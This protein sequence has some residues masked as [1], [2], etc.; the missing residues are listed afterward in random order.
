MAGQAQALYH[1]GSVS[2]GPS[3]GHTRNEGQGMGEGRGDRELSNNK[4]TNRHS[5][6]LA[7][8]CLSSRII[9][10]PRHY[11]YHKS[12]LYT[13]IAT[14]AA[15]G[16]VATV[17]EMWPIQTVLQPQIDAF[18]NGQCTATRAVPRH[19][20]WKEQGHEQRHESRE[21]ICRVVGGLRSIM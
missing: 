6:A 15:T 2:P 19:A 3:V 18:A 10:Q 9:R 12:N 1:D 8:T 13:T 20:W 16:A 7:S 4:N 21:T 11:H 17:A 5:L 14:D